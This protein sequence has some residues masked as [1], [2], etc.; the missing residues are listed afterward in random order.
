MPTYSI[1]DTQTGE[2]FD[3]PLD[4]D[5]NTFTEA[6]LDAMVGRQ[7]LARAADIESTRAR[8]AAASA[9]PRGSAERAASLEYQPLEIPGIASTIGSEMGAA[10]SRVAPDVLRS[11]MM[12]NAGFGPGAAGQ[13][14][15]EAIAR[16]RPENPATAATRYAAGVRQN[17]AYQG[18][19][20][21]AQAMQ[22]Y[23]DYDRTNVPEEQQQISQA[24]GGGVGSAL[25]Y[26]A[27]IPLGAAGLVPFALGQTIA[28][29]AEGYLDKGVDPSRA[30]P[31]ALIEGGVE[32]GSEFVLGLPGK[33]ARRLG[34]APEMTKVLKPIAERVDRVVKSWVGEVGLGMTQEGVEEMI[35][36]LAGDLS[37][38][39]LT[40]ADPQALDNMLAKRMQE[41]VGG[42]VGGAVIGPAARQARQ[43]QDRRTAAQD[44]INQAQAVLTAREQYRQA[45]LGRQGQPPELP[46]TSEPITGISEALARTGERPLDPNVAVG[47]TPE[48]QDLPY[49]LLSQINRGPVPPPVGPEVPRPQDLP[50]DLLTQL[51]AERAARPPAVGPNVPLPQDLPYDLLT[52]LKAEQ[53][54][55]VPVT[56]LRRPVAIDD[57]AAVAA[58]SE[59]QARRR[60]TVDSPSINDLE[61]S[62]SG[63][64]QTKGGGIGEGQ[65]QGQEKGLLLDS[66]ASTGAAARSLVAA[67]PSPE[68]APPTQ[69]EL[70]EASAVLSEPPVYAGLADAKNFMDYSRKFRDR[71]KQIAKEPSSARQDK[72][73]GDLLVEHKR[74]V[75][76]FEEGKKSK[77]LADLLG[78]AALILTKPELSWV[79][80]EMAVDKDLT[81]RQERWLESNIDQIGDVPGPDASPEEVAAYERTAR[82]PAGDLAFASPNDGAVPPWN[83]TTTWLQEYLKT[84]NRPR[85]SNTR[86]NRHV[87]MEVDGKIYLMPVYDTGQDKKPNERV[88]IGD[89]ELFNSA[90]AKFRIPA[91]RFATKYLGR[92]KFLGTIRL[93]VAAAQEWMNKTEWTPAE[94]QDVARRM[95]K[96]QADNIQTFLYPEEDVVNDLPESTEAEGQIDTSFMQELSMRE[97]SM[98]H[99]LD[100][101]SEITPDVPVFGSDRD[102]RRWAIAS[103]EDFIR[104]NEDA[105]ALMG[106]VIAV[107]MR[108]ALIRDTR[109]GPQSV[110]GLPL[111]I[112]SKPYE[113]KRW[114]KNQIADAVLAE[115]RSRP[116]F[117]TAQFQGLFGGAAQLSL[118][119]EAG[120][121]QGVVPQ[122]SRAGVA[123]EFARRVA[124]GLNVSVQQLRERGLRTSQPG[125][126]AGIRKR[127][128]ARTI[129]QRASS[130]ARQLVAMRERGEVQPLSEPQANRV[131]VKRDL[132]TIKRAVAQSKKPVKAKVTPSGEMAYQEAMKARQSAGSKKKSL[133]L[134]AAEPVS[135]LT[136]DGKFTDEFARAFS[137]VGG[138]LIRLDPAVESPIAVEITSDGRII[139]AINRQKL[140]RLTPE[141]WQSVWDE[142]LRHV[143]LLSFMRSRLRESQFVGDVGARVRQE[144]GEAWSSIDGPTRQMIGDR[145]RRIYGRALDDAQSAAELVRMIGQDQLTETVTRRGLGQRFLDLIT[146]FVKWLRLQ[147]KGRAPRAIQELIDGTAKV[148]ELQALSGPV[149]VE[150]A[151]PSE[152]FDA[153][154]QL[155]AAD[156]DATLERQRLTPQEV[157][158]QTNSGNL[159][160]LG[161]RRLNEMEAVQSDLL[162]TASR[163]LVNDLESRATTPI[164]P[165][166]AGLAR[167]TWQDE[168]RSAG[169]AWAR[170]KPLRELMGLVNRITS[171]PSLGQQVMMGAA[172]KLTDDQ[173]LEVGHDAVGVVAVHERLTADLQRLQDQ[174]ERAL[175]AEA[176]AL[177]NLNK[178]LGTT[179][180]N[181]QAMKDYIKNR[182]NS[183]RLDVVRAFELSNLATEKQ[184]VNSLHENIPMA[185]DRAALNSALLA[186][187]NKNDAENLKYLL[188]RLANDPALVNLSTWPIDE[189][190][191]YDQLVASNVMNNAIAG[192]QGLASSPAIQAATTS[193]AAGV[194]PPLK[195]WGQLRDAIENLQGYK[196]EHTLALAELQ[197]LAKVVDP[198]ANVSRDKSVSYSR[199]LMRFQ[200]EA[201][202]SERALLRLTMYDNALRQS[203]IARRGIEQAMDT[204]NSVTQSRQYSSIVSNAVSVVHRRADQVIFDSQPKDGKRAGTIT[205]LMPMPLASGEPRSE[206]IELSFEQ[207]E[208]DANRIKL[209]GL[210]S[211]IETWLMANPN[212]D[213]I[214]IETYRA[215]A[216]RLNHFLDPNYA[217]SRG[218][219]NEAGLWGLLAAPFKLPIIRQYLHPVL[220]EIDDSAKGM[221]KGMIVRAMAP[222]VRWGL[223]EQG[224][225]PDMVRIKVAKRKGMESHGLTVEFKARHILSP[226]TMDRQDDDY[227]WLVVEPI[228]RSGQN[229]LGF[230]LKAGMHLPDPSGQISTSGEIVITPEDIEAAKAQAEYER[231]VRNFTSI[232]GMGFG[233][234]QAIELTVSEVSAGGATRTRLPF[235]AGP[236]TMSRSLAHKANGDAMTAYR[237]VLAQALAGGRSLV[238]S[239]SRKLLHRLYVDQ[240]L[241]G[242]G[243]SGI[244]DSATWLDV[245]L[246][247]V[248]ETNP[249][250]AARASSKLAKVYDS[251]ARDFY[252]GSL[253]I[254]NWSGLVGLVSDRMTSMLGDVRPRAE[255]EADAEM[256]LGGELADGMENIREIIDAQ[257]SG[258]TADVH[259]T[260]PKSSFTTARGSIVGPPGLYEHGLHS[261]FAINALH[262]TV[263]RH[264]TDGLVKAMAVMDV[265]LGDYIDANSKP[266]PS[267][268]IAERKRKGEAAYKLTE[269]VKLQKAIKDQ[270]AVMKAF[271]SA[272]RDPEQYYHDVMRWGSMLLVRPLVSAVVNPVSV[273]KDTLL[274]VSVGATRQRRSLW[275]NVNWWFTTPKA[276]QHWLEAVSTVALASFATTSAGKRRIKNALLSMVPGLAGAVHNASQRV[277]QLRLEGA[278][279]GVSMADESALMSISG[280]LL[281]VQGALEY[282]RT[283]PLASKMIKVVDRIVQKIPGAKTLTYMVGESRTIAEDVN[284]VMFASLGD[285]DLKELTRRAMEALAT[286]ERQG[287]LIT[288]RTNVGYPLT[289]QELGMSFGGLRQ[290]RRWFEGS[291]GFDATMLAHY[292]ATKGKTNPQDLPL[293]KGSREAWMGNYLTESQVQT[294][295]EK[296]AVAFSKGLQGRVARSFSALKVWSSANLYGMIQG[297]IMRTKAWRKWYTRMPDELARMVAMFILMMILGAPSVVGI[298]WLRDKIGRPQGLTVEN[299]IREPNLQAFLTMAS[300]VATQVIPMSSLFEEGLTGFGQGSI[301]LFRLSPV[302]GG[303][304]DFY[305]A[306]STIASTTTLA[307]PS[308]LTDAAAYQF[309]RLLMRRIPILGYVGGMS[310]D[311]YRQYVEASSSIRKLAP[312]D[313]E[314]SPRGM[315]RIPTSSAYDNVRRAV[316]FEIDGKADEARAEMQKGLQQ[317]I[318]S[319]VEP[320]KARTKLQAAF[321]AQSGFRGGFERSLTE[322]EKQTVIERATPKQRESILNREEAVQRLSSLLTKGRSSFGSGF[323]GG[324][325]AALP[326][327]RAS[328][329]LAARLRA[330]KVR[331]AS[332]P[333]RRFIKPIQIKTRK[334][335][336]SGLARLARLARLRQKL[337]LPTA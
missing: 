180:G 156:P 320:D 62:A 55:S 203:H 302:L 274:T 5:I 91:G 258:E 212:A 163:D 239:A 211:E 219:I 47:R 143:A 254:K 64:T 284:A 221:S 279:R 193:P 6:E 293:P 250:Y 69:A 225:K 240:V 57:E 4:R 117:A 238:D 268:T 200:A 263:L 181:P 249:E 174:L 183:L 98:A 68:A 18:L 224:L 204:L 317:I 301:D 256:T 75:G 71:V 58:E 216:I 165:G 131:Q 31:Q 138:D 197:K 289:E 107:A 158:R 12:V 188:E 76:K 186:L 155:G 171:G 85:T 111:R 112:A 25:G 65:R 52:Q 242:R 140:S 83:A 43:I 332:S 310:D 265:A 70:D 48:G 303:A 60:L 110:G 210:I 148:M 90:E 115:V 99:L 124:P 59:R 125:D 287:M 56:R 149:V 202:K 172:P 153:S 29:A 308:S 51:N 102:I 151:G 229:S 97:P 34:L 26:A 322:E 132:R 166:L 266:V 137:R 108:S 244:T 147:F 122:G 16:G 82:M 89:P 141:Q 49:D 45:Q 321:A 185:G 178:F 154:I 334:R 190:S 9:L 273:L 297:E 330:R 226:F 192:G 35:S 264:V 316:Q 100:F 248:L 331:A 103:F 261:D 94:F 255:I 123:R 307:D 134:G 198:L 199:S 235:A 206:D 336:A 28:P 8:A 326:L 214:L 246:S 276:I 313:V 3:L 1:R 267:G 196:E 275:E 13:Y 259:A 189:D 184:L 36:G 87:F 223:F 277:S 78:N 257:A 299:L 209:A 323:G 173:R 30:I 135:E 232:E 106:K 96:I 218:T 160:T 201:K 7:R 118:D 286:R 309:S 79:V 272:S 176:K 23:Y 296:P 162:D 40:G 19:E 144:L 217:I 312:A 20:S 281:G 92:A 150:V 335:R 205:I 252:N 291:S 220:K 164:A 236:M 127:L 44:Y 288:D 33:I 104:T 237:G 74:E 241:R 295:R 327:P 11:A 88:M 37:A 77:D 17:P 38:A 191:F 328:R 14:V 95:S 120:G 152:R 42:A 146:D 306:M 80:L 32:A 245:V 298:D 213:P 93:P 81:A 101:V 105:R 194:R 222:F 234:G 53:G 195:A 39:Y 231:K 315:E 84:S 121:E 290:A 129:N 157:V 311:G 113:A 67:P 109:K 314:R 260:A 126:Y 2:A 128:K 41:F 170:L 46:Q 175:D 182:M 227:R 269:A 61:A 278:I 133:T 208:T 177:A 73:M 139:L 10:L 119:Q 280:S 304:M 270:L 142:E 285:S 72:L 282:E 54:A 319:G 253:T 167:R 145:M 292:Q 233:D 187:G 228:I 300:G 251:I 161:Q 130:K 27:T 271:E 169:M 21:I 333:T 114:F 329:N 22:Q 337:G 215:A 136:E 15:A 86:T 318:A 283:R 116:E 230:Q 262:G 66:T 325:G 243:T 179:A 159:G 63:E 24:L 294:L 247:H 324:G 50:Y 168:K 305:R 207:A